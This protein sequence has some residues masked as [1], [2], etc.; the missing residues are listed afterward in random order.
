MFVFLL[1]MNSIVINIWYGVSI[2]TRFFAPV[3]QW[4][5][6]N[7]FHC[8]INEIIDFCIW[9]LATASC[10]LHADYTGDLAVC[11]L[12]FLDAISKLLEGTS[13]WLC[14]QHWLDMMGV[15]PFLFSFLSG[16]EY[17]SVF[18]HYSCNPVIKSVC[19]VRDPY[20]DL[21]QIP[22]HLLL[23]QML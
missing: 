16:G 12:D 7:L 15:A 11:Q 4:V 3:L 23:G 17:Y 14:C 1:I 8:E 19:R 6:T 20:S 9:S 21:L 5:S 2:H 10:F 18:I 13:C 22:A